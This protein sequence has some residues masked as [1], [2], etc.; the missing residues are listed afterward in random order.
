[1]VRIK[2]KYL[3]RVKKK[4]L[5]GT[6]RE[7]VWS[8]G[9][10]EKQIEDLKQVVDYLKNNDIKTI[11]NYYNSDSIE[12]KV[13]NFIESKKDIK[14]AINNIEGQIKEIEENRES[15]YY[16][17]THSINT[18]EFSYTMEVIAIED[19]IVIAKVINSRQPVYKI[20]KH[21]MIFISK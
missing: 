16:K 10:I 13:F 3:G 14:E 9:G 4:M 6:I 15:N 2:Q 5:L 12:T 1:M 8:E 18:D 19:S 11:W 7:Y 20:R 21:D 17:N